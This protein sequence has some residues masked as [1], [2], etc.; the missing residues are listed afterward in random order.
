M[1]QKTCPTCQKQVGPRTRK[2]ECGH[3]FNIAVSSATASS[4]PM[5][6]DPLNEQ[7]SDS[8]AAAKQALASVE[9]GRT[10][11]STKK[12]SEAP[13]EARV[14]YV[15]RNAVAIPAG[16]PPVKPAGYKPEWP[17]GPA[18]DEVVQEWALATFNSGQ[19]VRYTPEA[20]VHWARYFWDINGL[21]FRRIRSL[22]LTALYNVPGNLDDSESQPDVAEIPS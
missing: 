12:V 8:L 3:E 22:V 9:T 4:Q 2:C 5:S 19:G 7:I 14:T 18:T 10:R 21:E 11:R 1:A 20:V 6:V 16:S 13:A 15:S 17:D